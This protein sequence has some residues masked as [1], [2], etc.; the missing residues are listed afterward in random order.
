[1]LAVSKKGQEFHSFPD[2]QK[3]VSDTGLLLKVMEEAW[4]NTYRPTCEY[5]SVLIHMYH[6]V[7]LA[8]QES[9]SL[10]S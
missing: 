1:M 10:D 8:S 2:V 6:V 3:K 4:Q 5:G 7:S 9:L